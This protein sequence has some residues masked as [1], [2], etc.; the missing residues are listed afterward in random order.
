MK[1]AVVGSYGVGMT[2]RFPKFP[3]AGETL[4]G[5]SFDAGPGGKGSNQAIG[6]ARLGAEV[7]FLT[8]IGPDEMGEAARALWEAEG[9][10]SSAVVVGKNHTMVGFILVDADG[11]NRIIVAAGALDEINGDHVEKF[12]SHIAQAEILVVSMELALS[13]VMAALEIGREEGVR[14]VLNP[15]PAVPLPERAWSLFDVITP[16]R[17]EAPVLLGLPDGHGLSPK[18]L[19]AA[20][21][22]KTSA[23]I[24]MTLG[25]EGCLVDDGAGIIATPAIKATNVVDTTGAGD[26]FTSALA[27]SLAEGNDV[28]TAVKFASASGAHSVSI[29]GVINSLPTREEIL[30]KLAE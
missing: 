16:N 27:V 2:M 30:K 7:S 8:A 12:R 14:I 29:A 10:D 1:I 20:L 6:A 19:V 15:A 22:E 25:S 26:S 21:R 4:M 24:I 23:Q 28:H 9:V 17:T 18:E 3:Q 11:E 13:A 5:G